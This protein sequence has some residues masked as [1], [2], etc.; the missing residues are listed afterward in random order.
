V[1]RL[2]GLVEHILQS[3]VLAEGHGL[4]E[5]ANKIFQIMKENTFALSRKSV[6]LASFIGR[7]IAP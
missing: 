4:E 2:S 7:P 1:I 3:R 5:D 6:I